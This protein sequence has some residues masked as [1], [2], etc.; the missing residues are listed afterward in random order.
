M[1]LRWMQIAAWTVLVIVVALIVVYM[2][3]L[4]PKAWRY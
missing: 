2:P 4:W 3:D 1:I